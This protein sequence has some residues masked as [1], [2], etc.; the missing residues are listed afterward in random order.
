MFL[1]T[2]KDKEVITKQTYEAG[3]NMIVE[4]KKNNKTSL[5]SIIFQQLGNGRKDQTVNRKSKK[6]PRIV[7]AKSK[8]VLV[9]ISGNTKT[10]NKLEDLQG[11]KVRGLGRSRSCS[12]YDQI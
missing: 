10:T 6:I 3:Q 9:L 12:L 4:Q 8:S 1:M 7:C 11:L 5:K 2:S